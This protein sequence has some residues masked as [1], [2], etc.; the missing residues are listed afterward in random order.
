MDGQN[1]TLDIL[2][3]QPALNLYTQICFCYPIHADA[4]QDKIITTLKRGLERLSAGFPWIAGQ[5]VN[6]GSDDGNT[7]VFKIKPL[8]NTPRLIIKDLRNDASAPTI[9]TLRGA[10][11]PFKMLDENVICP[12]NTI[13]GTSNE[14]THD[15]I[16]VFLVQANFVKGGLLLTFSGQHQ[17]MDMTGQG[18]IIDLFSK[19]CCGKDFT[20]EEISVGNL[21]RKYLIP[22]L[23]EFW[24]PGPEL[25]DSIVK[26]TQPNLSAEIEGLPAA[27][28][29]P[30]SSWAYLNF[31]AASLRALK[32]QA[33][34][35]LT[36]DFVS[37]DDTITA[38]IWQCIMRAR[39]PR[40]AFPEGEVHFAR[41]VDVRKFLNVPAEYPGLLQNMTY[42]S[43]PLQ[44]LIS[45]PLGVVASNLRTG[46]NAAHLSHH[47]RSLATYLSRT[48]DKNCVS[49]TATLDLS[50]DIMFSSWAKLDCYELDFGLE[51]GM[52]ECV[53]R[54]QLIPVESLGYLMPKDREGGIAV[55]ICLRDD[56]M[57]RL[58]GDEEFL[59][60]GEF[61]A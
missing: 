14:P 13:P 26:P 52:P 9:E 41:A 7:G 36:A 35:T 4:S 40:L 38:T 61:V 10:K 12:R 23:D 3:Q 29:I 55:A 39:A 20:Q 51:L 60:Y 1:D 34:S 33:F 27:P 56:D 6:E 50:A 17:T 59:K 46:L 44:K 57:E 43:F 16:P 28:V 25:A 8:E 48:P 18:Q 31:S 24:K 45:S 37:T 30:N 2:G 21:S 54:P 5:V 49:F 15:D 19:A 42:H 32:T 58:R 22:L 53:R 11:F 47:T